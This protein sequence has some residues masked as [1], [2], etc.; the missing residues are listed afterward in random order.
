M[1]RQFNADYDTYR[2]IMSE[3]LNPI[4]ANG[5]DADT[6]YRLYKSKLVYLENLRTKAFIGLNSPQATL[7]TVEDYQLILKAIQQNK[8]HLRAVILLAVGSKL[9]SKKAS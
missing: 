9:N 1:K 8:E 7:F 2:E 3:L 6:L 4:S 5:L